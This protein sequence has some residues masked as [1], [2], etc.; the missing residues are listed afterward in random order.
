MHE[1][2]NLRVPI[3]L[4]GY[5]MPEG[6]EPHDVET[7]DVCLRGACLSGVPAFI[8]GSRCLLTLFADSSEVFS[9][10]IEGHVVS[11]EDQKVC[12]EFHA[13]DCDDL[14]AYTAFLLRHVPDPDIICT[15]SDNGEIPDCTD[16]KVA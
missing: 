8:E 3:S 5:L 2:R 1:R 14:E 15:E 10:T 12:V 7:V 11:Q 16:W 13:M 6:T 9:V 4:T